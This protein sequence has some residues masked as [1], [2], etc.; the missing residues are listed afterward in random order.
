[1]KV[2]Q[3]TFQDKHLRTINEVIKRGDIGFG[4]NVIEFEKEFSTYQTLKHDY[5][6]STNC[7]SSAAYMIFAYLKEKY[8]SVDLYTPSIG[9]ASPVWAAKH[10]GHDITWV[11]V[12]ENLIFDVEDYRE[13]RKLRCERY[14]DCGIKPVLMPILYG[15][16]S[17]IQGLEKLKEDGYQEIMIVDS[18]HCVTPQVEADFTFFSFHPYK[19]VACSDGGMIGTSNKEASDYFLSY[20]N[21]GRKNV[22]GTYDITQDGFK[23]YMNN[24]NATIALE[25]LSDYDVN[26]KRREEVYDEWEILLEEHECKGRLLPHDSSSSY[27]FATF[28]S[29]LTQM[30]CVMS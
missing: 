30:K 25:S 9:F 8:G 28:I 15:G 29:K 26:L 6:V 22:N 7:A 27:Y 2:F 21:F 10:F 3:T 23:F 14:S 4:S 18:A 24:L 17:K 5:Y 16:V 19:P 12:D 1:M 11:D 13:K 20:R